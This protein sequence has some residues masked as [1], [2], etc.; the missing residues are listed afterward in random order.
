MAM[1]TSAEAPDRATK[2]AKAG[3]AADKEWLT[4]IKVEVE[5]RRRPRT[6]LRAWFFRANCLVF[7]HQ[8]GKWRIAFDLQRTHAGVELSVLGRRETAQR[9]LRRILV[10]SGRL[11]ASPSERHILA[12]WCP[13]VRAED[14]ARDVLVEMLWLAHRPNRQDFKSQ[15]AD[16]G[17]RPIRTYWWDAVPNFGDLVGPALVGLITG[18]DVVNIKGATSSGSV[19]YTAGSVFGLIRSPGSLIW[20]SGVIAPLSDSKVEYLRTRQPRAIHA[21]RGRH[22]R[23]E[24]VNKLGWKVPEVFGDPALLYPKF[25]EP[26]PGRASSRRTVLVPHYIH[27]DL[28][29]DGQ[30]PED[31]HVVNV[32]QG[33]EAVI[34]EIA[35]ADYCISSSLHGLIIAQAYG[36]PWTWLRIEDT[37]TVGDRFK[38]QDFF[39]CLDCSRISQHSIASAEVRSLDIAA[40]ARRAY[41]PPDRLDNGDL[42]SAFPDL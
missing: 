17:Y 38:F 16:T 36:V 34:D 25:Y 7:E 2:Q 8:I 27:K 21:V 9:F 22:T 39:S 14:V 24:L 3:S 26:T 13:G 30:L 15:M 11:V 12:T 35:N 10:T 31:V 4:A 18:R 42:L 6:L 20:G 41:R 29:D 37:P 32:G 28:F 5:G 23:T 33:P 40:L 19:L 1:G